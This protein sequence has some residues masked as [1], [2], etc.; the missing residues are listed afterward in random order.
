LQIK[1]GIRFDFFPSINFLMLGFV[2][3]E[4]LSIHKHSNPQG[5]LLSV[6]G[7]AAVTTEAG[8]GPSETE[9]AQSVSFRLDPK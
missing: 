6:D 9:V 2:S 5:C 4:D 3:A 1:F 7:R 8:R